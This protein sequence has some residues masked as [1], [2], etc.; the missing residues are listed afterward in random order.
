M[1]YKFLYISTF[2]LLSF[3]TTLAQRSLIQY[4]DPFIGTGGHGHTYPGAVLPHGMVQLS[5]DTRL[6]GWDGCGGYHYSDNYL[7]GFTHTHLSGTGVS[8]YGDILLMPMTGKPSPDNKIY[9]SAFSHENEKASPGYY[10]VRLDDD[11]IQVEL[12]AT[13]RVGFHKYRFTNADKNYIILDLKHRDEVIESSLKIVNLRTISGLRR[14]KAWAENQYVYFVVEF[15]KPFASS[16]FWRNDSL[17]SLGT[18]N[19]KNAKNIKAFFKF[20]SPE[21]MA[22]VAIS[23]VSEEGALKNLKAELPGW[24]FEQVKLD[25]QEKW[26]AELG[27]V[28][29][30]SNDVKKLRTFYTA[31]YHTAIVPN[32]NQDV[33][34]QYRGRDN[35]IHLANGFTNYSVF[36]LWD[37]Y[38]GAHPLYTII[39]QKRT[40]DYIKSFLVQY[41]QG[42]RLPVWE[43]SSCETNCMIGYHSVPVIVDA[44]M[45]GITRFDTKLALEAMKKSATWNHFGLP[46]FMDHGLLEMDDEHESVSKT[47]EYAYDDWCIAQF[48]KKLGN[49]TDYINYTRRAQSYKNL[50]DRQ[51]GFMRPRKN[52]N[53]LS[54]FDPREVNNNFTEANSWQYSFYTPQDIN[55]YIEMIGGKKMMEEK[56]DKLFSENSKTTG[57]DQSDITGLIG[58]YAHGNEPSH[59]IAYLYNF[60]GAA[61]KTQAMVH[62]IMNDMYHDTPDGL[63]GNEDC[64]QMSAWYVLS[65]LGFYPVTPGTTDYIIGTPLFSSAAIHLE[66]GKTFTVKGT[67]V[68]DNNFYIQAA[69]LNNNLYTR[70][71]ISHFDIMAGGEI[72]FSM[73]AMPSS[74]GAID[75]PVTAITDNQIVLNPVIDAG[76]ISFKDKK[77]V[78]IS[79]AQ[80]GLSFY[81]TTDGSAPSKTSK[82]YGAAFSIN[83]S[84][85]IKAIAVNAK[86]E[87]SFVTT[88]MYRKAPHNWTI[89][90]NTAYEQQYDGNGPNGLIDD[91][92][93]EVD[94]RK[95]NWQGYQ[96]TDLDVLID[97]QK[98]ISISSVHIRLLQDTRAWIVL[99]R[100]IIIEV[101]NDNIHFTQVYLGENFLP[102]EDETAQLKTVEAGFS[103]VTARYVRVKALQYGKLPA[104]HLGAGGDTHIFADEI[105]VK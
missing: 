79:A 104:W 88:A 69:T 81:Y 45:K 101:S 56:L 25:A 89:K 23:S 71:Y 46:A 16:G 5:P 22:K 87:T 58:Q 21:L 20:D 49:E 103:P 84:T 51:T 39:D 80:K 31:L 64:G 91:I 15:S 29:V 44:Y 73:G 55:G 50:L 1:K 3:F 11:N 4:V 24:D 43:L 86:G 42:G 28:N 77:I 6:D 13:T 40:L 60:T 68:R 74:F 34:G 105:V 8:D 61:P 53:W 102:I 35:Q 18:T 9:G 27:K 72:N 7:Y 90:L 82:K 97:L 78:K 65:A 63:E 10:S 52:G 36:S 62:R 85:T 48:A 95:G 2:V 41:Q 93:G 12:T 67:N 17:L 96:K 59:H 30:E 32:I 76:A 98:T 92:R 38:R 14:S 54:P 33:D 26:D 66:N 57:R 70:S 100:Q 99:P 19:V 47:L 37:T 94:W 75:I 83:K